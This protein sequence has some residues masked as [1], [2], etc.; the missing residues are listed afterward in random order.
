[1]A[2]VESRLCPECEGVFD[3]PAPPPIDRRGFLGLVGAGVAAAAVPALADTTKTAK[4]PRP[5]EDLVR[6]LTSTLADATTTLK[7][8]T[9]VLAQVRELLAELDEKLVLLD[10][11]PEMKAKIEAI[12][13][14]V[15]AR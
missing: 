4:K 15:S 7:D 14:I 10:E 2:E 9:S 12:H 8:A 11:V 13:A 6:E 1:M 3:Y 5:A